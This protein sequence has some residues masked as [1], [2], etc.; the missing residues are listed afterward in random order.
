MTEA[1]VAHPQPGLRRVRAVLGGR[2]VAD[3]INPLL[4]WE[5]PHHPL[6]YIPIADVSNELLH[7]T[8][9]QKSDATRGVADVYDVVVDGERRVGAARRFVDTD[10]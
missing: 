1:P 7:A 10:V 9:Q 8:G 6:Y 4:V 2:V 3:T 5:G